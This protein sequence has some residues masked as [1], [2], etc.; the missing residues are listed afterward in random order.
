[1]KRNIY[2][3]IIAMVL[4][5]CC[6]AASASGVQVRLNDQARL[7]DKVVTIGSIA[8]VNCQDESLRSQLTNMIVAEKDQNSAAIVV[9]SF[10]IARCLSRAGINPVTVDIYGSNECRVTFIGSAG[11][12][13]PRPSI[14]PVE[15]TPAVDAK[16]SIRQELSRMVANITGYTADR[17]VID[18]QCS[19]DGLLDLA[20]D[21]ARYEIKPQRSVSLGNVRFM[22]TDKTPALPENVLPQ[23]EKFYNKPR[24]FYVNGYVQYLSE[25][26]VAAR[27]L[28]VGEIIA[29]SDVKMVPQLVTAI[30]QVGVSSV[31]AVIGKELTRSVAAESIVKSNMVKRLTLVERN[32]PVYI[33]YNS[34]V[35]SITA[36]GQAM[37]EGA[38][39]DVIAV[40]VNH[41]KTGQN[42]AVSQVLYCRVIAQGEVVMVD[43]DMF[44]NK[45]QELAQAVEQEEIR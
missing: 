26:V 13:E 5:A 8:W 32:T 11:R 25:Y 31:E 1:M 43:E 33:R 39:N 6:A 28:K 20:M 17:L 41:P 27:D 21:N 18:W 23:H 15:Q 30:N 19:E 4:A 40:K 22:V 16:D 38:L 2:N 29:A 45:S 44:G 7:S 36:K 35:I 9:S 24:T 3:L 42:A 34:S 10:D 14:I 12:I 37:E